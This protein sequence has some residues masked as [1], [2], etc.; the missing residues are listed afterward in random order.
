MGDEITKKLALAIKADD[1]DKL[2]TLLE[3]EHFRR[4]AVTPDVHGETLLMKTIQKGNLKCAAVLIKEYGRYN[5][6]RSKNRPL[7][8]ICNNRYWTALHFAA[9]SGTFPIARLLVENGADTTIKDRSF[10]SAELIALSSKRRD[11]NKIRILLSGSW[12]RHGW[13]PASHC[14]TSDVFHK[15]VIT[16]LLCAKRE[17]PMFYRDIRYQIISRLFDQHYRKPM[18]HE[19]RRK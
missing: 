4:I 12:K 19:E 6:G 9:K 7:N 8:F 14:F 10:W 15:E 17:L 16:F 5:H 1:S 13:S 3:L 18:W 11:S 2:K